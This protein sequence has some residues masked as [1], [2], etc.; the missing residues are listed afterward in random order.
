M[1]RYLGRYIDTSGLDNQ[2]FINVLIIDGIDGSTTVVDVDV[3]ISHIDGT[4]TR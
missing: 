3:A 4:I 1:Y 2:Y